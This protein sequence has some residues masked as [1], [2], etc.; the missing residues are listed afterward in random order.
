MDKSVIFVDCFNTVIMRKISPNQILYKW[1]EEL[2]KEFFIEPNIIYELYT[3]IKFDMSL[4]NLIK[5]FETE[6][7]FGEVISRLSSLLKNKISDLDEEKFFKEA[8][9]SYVKTEASY[10]YLN[11]DTIKQLLD[12]KG[13]NF[14]IY[15]VSDFYCSNYVI[16]YWLDNLGVKDLFDDVFVSCDFRKSKSTGSLY[17]SVLKTLNIKRNQVLMIGDNMHSDVIMAMLNGVKSTHINSSKQRLYDS[18]KKTLSA[19][20]DKY[21][22]QFE[23]I[24]DEYG[25]KLNFSN[26]AFPLFMFTKRLYKKLSQNNIKDVFFIS[27]E[28]QYLKKL[29]DTYVSI[30]KEKYSINVGIN[31]HYLYASRNS[32]LCASLNELDKED[33]YYLFR[34]S[35]SMSIRNFLLTLNF[36]DEQII[37][38]QDNLQIDIDKKIKNFA[39]S[40]GFYLLKRNQQFRDIYNQKRQDQRLAF[41][42]YF[43]EFG[44]NVE[45][46]GFVMVDVGWKGTMQDLFNKYF[47]GKVSILGY[48]VGNK[49]KSTRRSQK[50]G[51]LYDKYNKKLIG[52]SINKHTIFNYEQICRAD[53]NRCNGYSLVDG[54]AKVLFD[55]KLN[56][57]LIYK[58]ITEP[59]QNLILEKF[60]KIAYMD[61]LSLSNIDNVATYMYYNLIL[62]KSKEDWEWLFNCQDSHHDNFGDIKYPFKVVKKNLRMFGFR[63]LD[64]MFIIFNYGKIKNLVNK[65]IKSQVKTCDFIFINLKSLFV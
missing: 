7:Y 15:I 41:T 34:S 51:L 8:F 38:V 4:K 18:Y 31:T 21:N 39:K 24:F 9:Y 5:K 30:I 42:K 36:S 14:K 3:K 2:G 44:V 13:K 32:M 48:Y 27:R 61:D 1:A 49:G 59:M 6:L 22:L 58:R 11:G 37:S 65:G 60:K 64:L 20:K 43:E 33:F 16:K 29:F 50:Y 63:A 55:D 40:K 10:H 19:S 56:D 52:N 35:S 46:D 62:H 45:R 53:H 28:G 17:R 26:H 54:K 12:Y 25:T 47:E 23:N 57:T